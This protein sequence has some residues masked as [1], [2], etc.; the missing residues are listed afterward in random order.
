MTKIPRDKPLAPK[1]YRRVPSHKV[2]DAYPKVPKT[3]KTKDPTY[4]PPAWRTFFDGTD[5]VTFPTPADA[6][7]TPTPTPMAPSLSPTLPYSSHEPWGRMEGVSDHHHEWFLYFCSLGLTRTRQKVADRFS[8]SNTS[9]S[10]VARA[11][12]WD[13]RASSWDQFRERQYTIEML[14][15]T[16]QM[17]RDHARI[18]ADGIRALGVAF[19]AIVSRMNTDP[20]GFNDSLNDLSPRVLL[21]IAQ[22]SAQVIPQLM[23]AERISRGL[24]TELTASISVIDQRVTIQGTDDL[25]DILH[26]VFG[27]LPSRSDNDDGG[28]FQGEIEDAVVL[29]DGDGEE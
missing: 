10:K 18:A 23:S 5:A 20:E 26:S 13:N 24:P 25:L 7:N 22:R 12:D 3:P 6:L 16:R 11:E 28:E 8:V 19:D 29:A 14:D 4:I 17:A 27:T 9:V 15:Q 21:A 1:P 2:A